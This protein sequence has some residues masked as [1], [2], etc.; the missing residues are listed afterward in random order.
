MTDL[1]SV[2]R[3]GIRHDG[4]E[5]GDDPAAPGVAFAHHKG[6]AHEMRDALNEMLARLN[7][8]DLCLHQLMSKPTGSDNELPHVDYEDAT[9]HAE[10]ARHNLR[11]LFRIARLYIADLEDVELLVQT[12]PLCQ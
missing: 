12:D 1:Q 10:L 3:A 6:V 4:H 11:G 7:D 9:E 2:D 8:V 5:R